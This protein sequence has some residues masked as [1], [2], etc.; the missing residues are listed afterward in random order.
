MISSTHSLKGFQKH[1]PVLQISDFYV[2]NVTVSP[3]M[4]FF[5]LLNTISIFECY[6][7]LHVWYRMK[8]YMWASTHES[9]TYKHTKITCFCRP[10]V[11]FRPERIFSL[12]WHFLFLETNFPK[13]GILGGKS[14]K[15]TSPLNSAYWN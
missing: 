10:N 3:V 12:N 2:T 8:A 14:E 4:S 7:D 9:K 13:K 1:A 5:E 15:W 6:D 11:H